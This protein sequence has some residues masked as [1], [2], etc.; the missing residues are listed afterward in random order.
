MSPKQAPSH[1]WVQAGERVKRERIARQ[2]AGISALRPRFYDRPCAAAGLTSYRY[3]GRYGWIMIGAKD[4]AD[5]MR[6]ASR[7]TSPVAYEFLDRWFAGP[8]GSGEYRNL[9]AL[10]VAAYE[11]QGM[12]TSDAQGCADADL[13]REGLCA[14]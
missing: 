7:S 2:V 11:A 4:D 6:E 10:R 9:Y 8:D 5:A 3:R 1:P 12:D 13:M 14:P